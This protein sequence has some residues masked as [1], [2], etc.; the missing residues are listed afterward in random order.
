[1]RHLSAS[2]FGL[3]AASL[4]V[5]ALLRADSP[6]PVVPPQYQVSKVLQVGGEGRWDLLDIDPATQTLYVPRSTHVQIIKTA[7]EVVGD[8]PNTSGV[9][10]AAVAAEFGRGFSSDGKAGTVT[11]FDLKT[12]AAIGTVQAGKNPDAILYDPASKKVFAFNGKSKDATVINADA[13][14]GSAP[15]ATIALSG[16]PEIAATDGAG[17]VY[18]NLEDASSIAVIDSLSLKVIATWKIE[19]GEEPSGLAIDAANHRLFAGCGG[20]NV[21]AVVDIQSG[22]TLATLPIGKG[23]DGCAFDPGTGC[24]MASCGDGTLTIVKETSPGKFEVIQ[25]L[26]TRR[27]AR[28]IVLDPTTHAAYLPTAKMKDPAP[29]E[30]RPTPEPGTFMIVVVTLASGK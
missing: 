18:V 22:K 7:G 29:G 26:Q 15:T 12:K 25:T 4:L 1:M 23:V 3:L 24:A 10:G 8:I 21:M 13:A 19:G 20:N 16:K 27:G 30:R 2:L 5:P 14:P 11:I 17:H 6:A 28:T 9:H